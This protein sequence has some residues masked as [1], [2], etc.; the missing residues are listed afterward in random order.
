MTVRKFLTA[1]A[2]FSDLDEAD[3]IINT[4]SQYGIK[5]TQ[6]EIEGAPI[7]FGLW[8]PF[9]PFQCGSVEDFADLLERI[10][11]PDNYIDSFALSDAPPVI[12]DFFDTDVTP[13]TA[14]F[15]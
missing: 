12:S 13:P 9:D 3:T 1:I 2:V 5:S 11:G 14:N 8:L 10:I 15:F 4:L 7:F 6:F